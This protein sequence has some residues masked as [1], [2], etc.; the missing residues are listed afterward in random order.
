MQSTYTLDELKGMISIHAELPVIISEGDS[1]FGYP[2]SVI[3]LSHKGTNIIDYIEET[4]KYNILR[5]ES[6]GDTAHCMMK[7]TQRAKMIHV[8]TEVKKKLSQ[9]HKAPYKHAYCILFSGGGND[10]VGK[11]DMPRFLNQ[12][13]EGM[14]AEDAICREEFDTELQQIKLAYQTLIKLRDSHSLETK[15]I[16]H[17][18]DYLIPSIK[19]AVF[20]GGLFR[21][22]PW[23]QPFMKAVGI[24]E[25]IQPEIIKIMIQ[26]F[27]TILDD[28]VKTTANFIKVETIG[29]V[30]SDEWLNEIHPTPDA[31]GKIAKKVIQDMQVV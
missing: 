6:N 14:T 17:G 24:P 23:I 31:F 13:L 5:L 18:Y 7:G 9:S 28:L 8:L 3:P 21:S 12:W 19:G 22:G 2:T 15:I 27:N 30:S 25:A 11:D 26:D 10:I 4:K 16:T 20:F 1:W 29:T